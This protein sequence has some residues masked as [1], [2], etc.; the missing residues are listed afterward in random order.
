M[1]LRLNG[2]AKIKYWFIISI[3]VLGFS[4]Y[5]KAQTD[6][7]TVVVFLSPTCPICQN[8]TFDLKNLYSDFKAKGVG[9]KGI[10]PAI[11]QNKIPELKTFAEKYELDFPLI[12]DPQLKFASQMGAGITPTVYLLRNKTN[13]ILYQGK[14]NNRYEEV[15]KRRQVVTE[16]YL[17]DAILATLNGQKIRINKTSAVGCI[18][19]K[20]TVKN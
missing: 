5:S 14:I 9:F 2:W 6:S 19:E 12:P 15:G 16:N 7:L 13:E 10:F 20:P 1:I 4:T 8:Q 18:I 17:K 3:V 11:E